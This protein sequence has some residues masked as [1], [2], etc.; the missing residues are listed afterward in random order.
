MAKPLHPAVDWDGSRQQHAPDVPP[1]T[2]LA[3]PLCAR[4]LLLWDATI[5]GIVRRFGHWLRA[6][7]H[8]GRA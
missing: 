1:R 3:H 5:V 4:G 6:S 7:R 8:M 2:R